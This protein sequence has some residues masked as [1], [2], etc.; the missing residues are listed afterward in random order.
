[1]SAWKLILVPG[2]CPGTDCSKG[3]AFLSE[4]RQSRLSTILRG[5]APQQ[6]EQGDPE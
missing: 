3:S 4:R 6:V 1:M 5:K 2:L